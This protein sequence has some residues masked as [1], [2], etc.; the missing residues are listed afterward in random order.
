MTKLILKTGD[1]FSSTA[2]GIGHGVNTTGVMGAGIAPLFKARH[3][4]MYREY[5]I[6]CQTGGLVAGET[7]IWAAPTPGPVIYNIASQDR[8]GAHARLEWLE[9]GVRGALRDA[10]MRGVEVI[11]LPRI[12]C[13]I[14]GL[15]WVDVEP[16]LAKLAAETTCDL[17]VWTL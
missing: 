2:A 9:S 14:G 6:A 7:M 1:L 16:L 3:P 11:A 17:E 13:G 15:D 10:D 5:R 8:P 12:G 4:E